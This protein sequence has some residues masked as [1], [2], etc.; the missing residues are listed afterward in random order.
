MAVL[1]VHHWA[2]YL[3]EVA[4]L[5]F[6]ILPPIDVIAGWLGGTVVTEIVE[7]SRDTPDWTLMSFWAHPE[8]VL[9]PV[10]RASTSGFARMPDE[11]VERVRAVEEDLSTGAWDGRHRHLRELDGFDAGVRLVVSTPV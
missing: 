1:T 4:A 6:R 5:D 9:D 2:D 8:R 7:V 11:V 3:P 10:A